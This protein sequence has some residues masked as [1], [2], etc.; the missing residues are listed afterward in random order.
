MLRTIFV[1]AIVLF[2]A[3]YA[4]RDAFGALLLYLWIAYFRPE[5][6]LWY[7][8]WL[9]ALNLSFLFGV[10]LLARAPRSDAKFRLDLRSSL[11]MMFLGLSLLSTLTS[12]YIAYAWPW[13][14]NFAKA[15]VITYLI[16][17]FITDPSRL[18][19]VVLVIA[20]SQG[21]ESAKQGWGNFVL[22]PGSVNRNSLA[23]LGDENEVALGLLMLVPMYFALAQ[24]AV[25]R[26][27]R[28][29]HRVFGLGVAYRAVATYSR[30]GFL[31]CGAMVI[32]FVLRSR[33][34]I[35]SA[36]AIAA[37]VLI[38][39]PVM[40]QAFWDRMSSIS[41]SQ[42]E[43][44]E[45]DASQTG[46]IHFWRVALVMV[47]DHPLL[48]VGHN[49][50]N[51]AYDQYDFSRGAYGQNRSVHSIWF[52]ILSELGIPAFSVYLLILALAIVGCQRVAAR[53]KRGEVSADL[54]HFAIA[55][56]SSFTV[57][58][59]AGTFVPFQYKEMLWHFVGLSTALY[60]LGTA[61]V[62][63][64]VV[65]KPSLPGANAAFRPQHVVRET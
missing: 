56:Q 13:W 28:W 26:T 65:A 24:T 38:V 3:Q 1:A 57:L 21:I 46:R 55:L 18:R 33:H 61:T 30:G 52:G 51:A 37:V 58:I 27:E 47:S 8:D 39:I 32:V 40:P 7:A 36:L 20:L 48:G 2:G 31:A 59:V 41:T 11:L 25:G 12:D 22:H 54:G 64:S 42:D 9:T 62:P 16:S 53:A 17:S 43:L 14:V 19:M 5:T 23:N 34:K 49:S 29:F 4:L 10:Y 15:M 35:R 63:V 44:E 60:A 45:A 6:W 50:F